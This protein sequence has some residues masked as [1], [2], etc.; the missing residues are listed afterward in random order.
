MDL[1]YRTTYNPLYSTI[2]Q[3]CFVAVAQNKP[4]TWERE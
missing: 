4:H 3:P 2:S 1:M